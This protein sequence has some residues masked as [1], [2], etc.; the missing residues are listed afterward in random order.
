MRKL[1]ILIPAIAILAWTRKR[2]KKRY[3]TTRIIKK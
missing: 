1:I 2:R 3:T